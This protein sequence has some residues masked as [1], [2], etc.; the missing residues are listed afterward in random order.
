MFRHGDVSTEVD[1]KPFVFTLIAAVGSSIATV[2]LFTLSRGE[3]LAIFAGIM[4]GVV[5]AAALFIL[6]VMLTDY[7]YIENGVL[8]TQYLLKRTRIPLGD[9]GKITCKENVYS[10]YGK[11][12]EVLATINGLLTGIGKIL[13]TL[14][15]NGVRFE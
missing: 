11:N 13:N 10:V 15:K 7:A 4:V 14:E 1:R 9:I 2:L 5:A 12:G 3:P 6:I 8:R